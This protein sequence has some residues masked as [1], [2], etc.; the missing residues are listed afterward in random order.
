MKPKFH[1]AK[2]PPSR[3]NT[4]NNA[5]SWATALVDER[6]IMWLAGQR[7]DD[8]P[9]PCQR[10][11]LTAVMGDALRQVGIDHGLIR[12]C[13]FAETHPWANADDVLVRTVAAH[14][15]DGG[16]SLVRA[17][18]L[19]LQQLAQRGANG[20]VLVA[21]DDERLIPYVD[22]AQWRGLKVLMVADEASTQL[23]QLSQED[24][25]WARLLMQADRRVALSAAALAA[26]SQAGS[27]VP[28]PTTS[29]YLSM[30]PVAPGL[31]APSAASDEASTSYF[32]AP[33]PD[34]EWREQVQAVI[35]QWWAE[36]SEEARLDLMDEMANS[37]GVPSE[38]DRHL[39]LRVRRVLNRTLSF[40]EK[41]AMREMIR[42]TVLAQ[43]S[44]EDAHTLEGDAE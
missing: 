20:W 36:E 26:L 37:Q 27:P 16:L 42:Q 44:N 24:P 32:T 22:D 28:E 30:A 5:M 11:A 29:H 13:L 4:A 17:M 38:T 15:V 34:T 7:N 21:S 3:H 6:Y 31:P 19:E 18:G 40:Q 9:Q 33:P 2:R 39:L 23:E 10:S 35:D 41:K 25:S 8:G 1:L 12:T 14:G 43:T